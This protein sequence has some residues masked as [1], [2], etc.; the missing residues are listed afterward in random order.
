MLI[1]VFVKVLGK[2]LK[3][4]LKCVHCFKMHLLTN[5]YALF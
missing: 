4:N 5:R 2:Y 3:Y 1:Y